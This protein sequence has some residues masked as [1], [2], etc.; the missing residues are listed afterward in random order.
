MIG[1]DTGFFLALLQDNQ[2]AVEAWKAGLDDRVELVVS[3][4]S[5]FE[6]ERLGLK[7]AIRE[8]QAL[9]EAIDAAT[10]VVWPSREI[11]GRAARLS[12]GNKI[13]AIDSIILASLLCQG[14]T[15]IYTT[16]RHMEAYQASGVRIVNLG[17]GLGK[18]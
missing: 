1:L 9:V 18:N 13:P 12:H 7:G 2:E 8:A 14:A 5:L 17:K 16:D 3:A 6:I 15:T 10:L 11:L 4:I